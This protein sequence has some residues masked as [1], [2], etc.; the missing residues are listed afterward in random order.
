MF[1]GEKAACATC[2]AI[3]PRGGALGPDLTSIGEI[4]SLP[5][6]LEAI[7]L[8]S[9]TFV[10]GYEPFRIE[11][12]DDVFSGVIGEQTES[13]VT[14]RTAAETEVRIPRGSTVALEPSEV[15]TMPEGLDQEL[16]REELNDLLAFLLAQNGEQWLLPVTRERPK[17]RSAES[18]G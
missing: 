13:A 1:F 2:H 6:L 10:P 18:G 4:R 8:P 5:D 16:A 15:S 7:V 17:A 3:G 11:T 9:S 14:L 12:S